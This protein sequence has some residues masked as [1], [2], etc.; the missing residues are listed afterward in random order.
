METNIKDI[1]ASNESQLLIL[2]KQIEVL[3]RHRKSLEDERQQL[4]ASSA[5]CWSL[6]APINKIPMEVLAIIIENAI[7]D[8]PLEIM[9]V[10]MISRQWF[11]A[12][13]NFA[14]LWTN[15]RV[16][17]KLSMVH[18]HNY[19][20]Y[21]SACS[22]RSGNLPLSVAIC[23][24]DGQ[25]SLDEP[26]KTY[27]GEIKSNSI[28]FDDVIQ[29]LT[30]LGERLAGPNGVHMRRWSAFHIEGCKWNS[31]YTS[32]IT[33][34]L[35]YPLPMLQSFSAWDLKE[36]ITLDG[37]ASLED[38]E[39]SD[40]QV[41]I[42][43]QTSY[44]EVYSLRVGT[45]ENE[46]TSY[47]FNTCLPFLN[48]KRLQLTSSVLCPWNEASSG[49]FPTMDLPQLEVLVLYGQISHN[50]LSR[51]KLPMLRKLVINYA[52]GGTASSMSIVSQ[53]S[54]M[55]NVTVIAIRC[56]IDEAFLS[57]GNQSKKKYFIQYSTD[58]RS[59]LWTCPNLRWIRIKQSMLGDALPII[60][61]EFDGNKFTDFRG[62]MVENRA[63]DVVELWEPETLREW[64]LLEQG[65]A[66]L[67]I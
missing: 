33:S 44:A 3:D 25:L 11:H 46:R 42:I 56:A 45:R 6:M 27:N 67:L 62:V 19:I 66:R 43:P 40:A 9:A 54:W 53:C 13:N 32:T 28:A 39:L 64:S 29:G 30:L 38:V 58:L 2:D 34:R 49:H 24:S 37:I 48:I 20:A 12:A 16:G 57:L 36:S 22:H 47:L 17:K 51:C 41:S 15:V 4:L 50:I 52:T 7:Q 1:I 21:V 5:L 35:S 26:E 14:A 8:S 60:W 65:P 18:L 59:L 55:S 10:R 31:K 63:H 23:L 61:E